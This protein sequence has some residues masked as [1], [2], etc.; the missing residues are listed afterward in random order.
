MGQFFQLL[1]QSDS[2]GEIPPKFVQI[3]RNFY[4]SYAHAV[5]KNGHQ[6]EEYEA[7]LALYLQEVLAAFKNPPNF[8]PY[9][10]KIRSPI[11]Y[12]ALGLDFLR[13]LVIFEKSKVQGLKNLE[14]IEKQLEQG[15]NA[16]LFA[17]HQT[18]PDPQ[19]ISLLLEKTHPHIAEEMIFVAGQRVTTDPL[20]IPMS[21]GRNLLCIYSKRYIETPP[22]K[23][24]EKQLHNQR[25]MKK[26]SELLKEGGKCIYVAPSGGRDRKNAQ[27]IVEVAPLDAASVEMFWLMAKAAETPTHF[28]PLALS[29]YQLLPP[30]NGV[31]KELGEKREAQCTPIHLGFGTEIDMLHFPGSEGFGKREL[32]QRRAHYIWQKIES[33]YQS[34]MD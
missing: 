4:Q 2:K 17:N 27:G 10:A 30:P 28:Y 26:M 14:A 33:D 13:P 6:V 16:V 32:R 1:E 25:T 22:E 7:T 9:H 31:Q 15:E 11:D 12:Y 23:K 18:E 8:D 20:A 5:E 24:Q 29:T 34:L 19:A 3:L 21:L